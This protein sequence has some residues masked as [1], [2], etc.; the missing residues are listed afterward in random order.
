MTEGSDSSRRFRPI[1]CLSRTADSTNPEPSMSSCSGTHLF[2]SH[3]LLTELRLCIFV[4]PTPPPLHTHVRA[5]LCV[6]VCV[7]VLRFITGSYDRTCKVWDTHT[8]QARGSYDSLQLSN[9]IGKFYC[10]GTLEARRPQKCCL[11]HRFQ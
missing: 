11:R 10:S 7:R 4:F 3:P 2:S 9:L 1:S 6:C 8:G 5:Y